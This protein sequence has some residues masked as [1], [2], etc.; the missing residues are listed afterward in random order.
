M[1][2]F[3]W[4]GW[5][6]LKARAEIFKEFHWFFWKIDNRVPRLKFKKKVSNK[7]VGWKICKVSRVEKVRVGLGKNLKMLIEWTRLFGT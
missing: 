3:N 1:K 6:I 4:V 7:R 5:K 2:I